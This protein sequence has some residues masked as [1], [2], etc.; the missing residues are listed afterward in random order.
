LWDFLLQSDNEK[1]EVYSL[2]AAFAGPSCKSEEEGIYES[3]DIQARVM[4]IQ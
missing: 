2:G 3:W 4:A 1:G